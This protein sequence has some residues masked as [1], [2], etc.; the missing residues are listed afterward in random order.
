MINQINQISWNY[1]CDKVDIIVMYLILLLVNFG[2]EM[3]AVTVNQFNRFISYSGKHS[4][5][6]KATRQ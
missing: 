6:L 2:F 1:N 4:D 5:K 3:I